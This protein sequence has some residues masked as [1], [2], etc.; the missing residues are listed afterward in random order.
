MNF[1]CRGHSLLDEYSKTGSTSTEI[2]RILFKIGCCLLSLKNGSFPC[3]HSGSFSSFSRH[4]TI[5]IRI[6]TARKRIKAQIVQIDTWFEKKS[7][8]NRIVSIGIKDVDF[9]FEYSNHW[10]QTRFGKNARHWKCFERKTLKNGTSSWI[11]KITITC[12][13]H[14]RY[15]WSIWCSQNHSKGIVTLDI[16]SN[17]NYKGVPI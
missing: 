15:D 12:F 3:L 17:K 14:A 10:S 1:S 4:Q 8:S 2:G 11:G 9:N 5:W 13:S 6:W 7:F 16:P